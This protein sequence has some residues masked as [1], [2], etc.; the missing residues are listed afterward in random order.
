MNRIVI[1]FK[2][3][4]ETQ[5]EKFKKRPYVEETFKN[6]KYYVNSYYNHG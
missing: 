3:E 2:M 1:F 6:Y 4:K 5:K